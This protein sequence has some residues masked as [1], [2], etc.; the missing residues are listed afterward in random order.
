MSSLQIA[1]VV[2]SQL[3]KWTTE[4]K[5]ENNM[6]FKM[7]S[8]G[9]KEY[10]KELKVK[11]V[12]HFRARLASFSHLCLIIDPQMDSKFLNEIHDSKGLEKKATRTL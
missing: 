9:S 5:L 4:L 6:F 11:S 2:P 12:Q 10:A 3:R 7:V 1:E 8:F